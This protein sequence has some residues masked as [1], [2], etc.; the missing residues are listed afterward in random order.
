MNV[1]NVPRFQSHG[2]SLGVNPSLDCDVPFEDVSVPSLLLDRWLKTFALGN[3]SLT[4]SDSRWENSHQLTSVEKIFP[5][6]YFMLSFNQDKD[7]F[8][9]K[10]KSFPGQTTHKCV[11]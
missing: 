7:Y 9:K 2:K 3:L 5:L 11:L 8:K 6:Y 10:K 4:L 1:L